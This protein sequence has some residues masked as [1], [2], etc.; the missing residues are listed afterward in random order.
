LD[1][2]ATLVRVLATTIEVTS[3]D[4]SATLVRVLVTTTR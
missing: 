1:K 4:K 2:S 3:L